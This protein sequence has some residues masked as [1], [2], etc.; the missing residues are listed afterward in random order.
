[1]TRKEFVRLSAAAALSLPVAGLYSCSPKKKEEQ[2]EEGEEKKEVS[3]SPASPPFASH[4]GLQLYTVRE[5]FEKDSSGTLQ[6]IAA[7]GYKEMELHDPS[8]LS[9][10]KEIKD[11]GMN[12]ISTHFLSGYISGKWD[13]LKKFGQ[14]QP[15]GTI[16]NII[17]SCAKN[18]VHYMGI[19]ILFPEERQTLDDYKRF[20]EKTNV[21]AAKSKAAGVQMYYHN[22]SFEFEPIEN[23][24]P[25]E[26]LLKAFDKDLVKMELDL[27]WTTISGNDPAQWIEK[28]GDRIKML[29]LKDLKAGTP[30]DYTT[31]Q[32]PKEDFLAVGDGV[33]DFE[34]ALKAA[35][36]TGVPYAF[37]EQD[38]SATDPF[39]S[40]TR[41]YKYLQG[42]EL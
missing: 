24:T 22:H 21:V 31:F 11:L 17:E 20:A 13:S 27:F 39:E 28:M 3:A 16:D 30:K 37:V 10:T 7:I 40:I 36:K 29:H 42:L 32:V 14:P 26:E 6:K 35:H 33:V 4:P 38:H 8:A 41:S 9:R 23:T 5:K 1:M 2:E 12:V 34:K 18:E 15:P 25:I 19:S